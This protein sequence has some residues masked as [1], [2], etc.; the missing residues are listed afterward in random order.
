M[1]TT[2]TVLKG[3]PVSPGAAAGKIFVYKPFIA[4][5]TEGEVASGQEQFELDKYSAAK[6][7]ADEELKAIVV[8]LEKTDPAKAKIFVAHQDIL[9]D[10]A[11][12]EAIVEGISSDRMTGEWAIY[13][14]YAQFI[15]LMQKARDPLIRERAADFEDVRKR[16]LRI[17]YR[18]PE[19]NLATL[20]EPVIVVA[21]DLLPSDT[22]TLDRT[23]V[24]AILT[25]IG[26]PTSHSAIIAKS[27]EIPAVLGISGL[28]DAA[29]TGQQ[30]A[31]DADAGEVT[32]DPDAVT[33]LE[34]ARKRDKYL[35][36]LALNKKFLTVEPFTADGTRIDIGLNI[37]NANEKELEGAAYTDFVGLFRTEFL[38]MGK[39]T[40]PTEDEQF[41]VYKK[42]L[43]CYGKRPVTIRTL[44]IGGDKTL[45]CMD[46]PKEDNPFLGNRAL[47]LCFTHAGIFKTQL[48]ALYR[49]SVYGNLWLML[50]M[51]GSLDD[52]CRARW[53]INAV[54]ADLNHEGIAFGTDVKIGIMIEIPAI[55]M[56]ADLVAPEVDFAS[57]GTND[58]CQYLTAVDR[59]NPAVASYYQTFHPGLFRIMDMAIKAFVKAE[60]PI[61][62][63]G[64]MGGD[65]LA[66]P[67]LLGLGMRKLSMGQASVARV[68]HRLSTL[69]VPQ[70]EI[71]ANAVLDMH[72]A[73]EVEAY[74]KIHIL[75]KE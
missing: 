75:D 11:I 16:L 13:S 4:E 54:T 68:K 49:A 48:R 60:K 51:V 47:R 41:A 71:A 31:V 44:D 58:L 59:L 18:V 29:S 26:G 9:G 63:C 66:A 14:V 2:N 39:D 25:E 7:A 6:K 33:L 53:I 1:T 27:Y 40:L 37:G 46:L 65:E 15:R 30:A 38:Y 45:K 34:N 21:R 28:L 36:G 43:E 69:T 55:A 3:T 61:C 70:M 73:S 42:V 12:D 64:E 67:V 22:A 56:I 19:S 50:P 10:V 8:S 57:I 52:I 35:A 74:L 72:T 24:L 32:L 17:W 62:V 20:P 23:K 5:V